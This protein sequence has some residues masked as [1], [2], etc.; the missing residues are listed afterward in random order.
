MSYVSS[1]II[2]VVPFLQIL[3]VIVALPRY[4]DGSGW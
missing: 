2:I 3:V 4:S 1:V